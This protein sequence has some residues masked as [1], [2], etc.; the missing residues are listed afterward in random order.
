[1]WRKSLGLVVVALALAVVYSASA[2]LVTWYPLNETEGAV[3]NDASGNGNNGAVSDHT[4][5]VAGANAAARAGR[6][7]INLQKERVVRC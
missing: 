2:G 5:G 6:Y 4:W 3:A 7:G 1:M